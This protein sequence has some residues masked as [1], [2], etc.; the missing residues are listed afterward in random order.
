MEYF[1]SL[2]MYLGFKVLMVLNWLFISSYANSKVNMDLMD[3][4]CDNCQTN[5][6]FTFSSSSDSSSSSSASSSLSSSSSSSSGIV[7]EV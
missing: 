4:N 2:L 5:E 6:I 1:N 3:T 7:I